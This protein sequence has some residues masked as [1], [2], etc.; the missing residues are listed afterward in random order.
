[1]EANDIRQLISLAT[2]EKG[3]KM[4]T[5]ID[6]FSTSTSDTDNAEANAPISPEVIKEVPDAHLKSLITAAFSIAQTKGIGDLPKTDPVTTAVI[7]DNIVTSVK[8]AY[9]I[10]T[11]AISED[12]VA[13]TMADKAAVLC[14]HAASLVTPGLVKKG[15][16]VVVNVVSKVFPPAT[17]VRPF[18]KVI[19]HVVTPI[20]RNVIKAVKPVVKNVVRN[21]VKIVGSV[22]KGAGRI[23]SSVFNFFFG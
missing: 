19:S 13:E 5:F 23:I 16:D 11:G 14:D 21:T 15:L 7:S 12:N 17:I 8:T 4:E 10:A 2:L 18:T 20:V 22:L 3:S 1:M 9:G 6:E